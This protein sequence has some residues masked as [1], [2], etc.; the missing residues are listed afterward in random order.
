MSTF[1][2]KMS[3]YPRRV[4]SVRGPDGELGIESARLVHF[5]LGRHWQPVRDHCHFHVA[6]SP[7]RL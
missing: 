2:G 7:N 5:A 3:S 6:L 1:A 4:Q